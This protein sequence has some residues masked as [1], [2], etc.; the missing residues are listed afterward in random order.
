M[1]FKLKEIKNKTQIV[2]KIFI[3]K[4]FYIG[5]CIVVSFI[6]EKE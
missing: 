3:W 5:R 1:I 4:L 2:A 6:A